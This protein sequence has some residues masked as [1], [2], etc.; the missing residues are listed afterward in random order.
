MGALRL[1]WVT[2][3][4]SHA[5]IGGFTSGASIIIALSQFKYIVGYSIKPA[6]DRL[7]LILEEYFSKA[8]NLKWAEFIMVSR[9]GYSSTGLMLVSFLG[10]GAWGGVLPCCSIYR[11][12]H[13]LGHT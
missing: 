10:A 2:K 11:Y 12:M 6:S 9:W 3:F 13:V 4:L 8:H 5:V 1:G 7:N